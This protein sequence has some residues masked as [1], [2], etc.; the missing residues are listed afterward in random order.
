[1]MCAGMA[2]RTIKKKKKIWGE[3]PHVFEAAI[4]QHFALSLEAH[5]LGMHIKD[6]VTSSGLGANWD[7]DL[8]LLIGL[9]PCRAHPRCLTALVIGKFRKGSGNNQCWGWLCLQV[10]GV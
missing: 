2:R 6:D 1:M 9:P 8:D 3:A 4:Q 5:A 7:L 10:Q